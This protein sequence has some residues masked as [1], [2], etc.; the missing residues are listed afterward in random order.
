MW[1]PVSDVKGMNTMKSTSIALAGIL[2][3]GALGCESD[4]GNGALIGGG[5]GAL[6][7]GV[8]GHQS[9]NTTG[10]AL[11][12]GAVGA[13]T[14]ALVGHASD[15]NKKDQRRSYERGYDEGR[16]DTSSGYYR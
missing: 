13:G 5:I 15:E 4:T 9:G 10:G 11:I 3:F 1:R 2:S 8:I 14:G 7:G 6:A 16:R 12:G